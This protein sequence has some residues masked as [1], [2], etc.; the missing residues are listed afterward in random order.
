MLYEVITLKC[1]GRV[2]RALVG[3]EK[4]IQ[5]DALPFYKK[6]TDIFLMDDVP[7]DERKATARQVANEIIAKLRKESALMSVAA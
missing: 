5:I 6:Y 7:E 2:L 3:E 1:H 4:V